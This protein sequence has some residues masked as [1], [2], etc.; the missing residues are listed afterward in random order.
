MS[1]ILKRAGMAATAFAGAGL[2]MAGNA[3]AEQP[4]DYAGEGAGATLL[5]MGAG[6]PGQNQMQVSTDGPI[7]HWETAEQENFPM[8]HFWFKKACVQ[9]N[10]THFTQCSQSTRPG[11]L[12]KDAM[13][14]TPR[15][16]G[17]TLTIIRTTP[18]TMSDLNWSGFAR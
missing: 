4:G 5:R 14:Q 13:Q 8:G 17:K 2:I 10:A 12:P 16:D 7:S 1:K 3:Y 18:A 11:D 6:E 15:I 9:D